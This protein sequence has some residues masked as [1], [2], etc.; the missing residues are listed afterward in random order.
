MD[1][2]FRVQKIIAISGRCSR[3]K[4]EEL[5]AEGRVV[6]NGEVVKLGDK[7]SANDEI[8]IDGEV[9]E[10]KPLEPKYIILN[11]KVGFV[12][13]NKDEFNMDTVFNLIS[14]ED[15]LPNMFTVGRLDKDTSGLLIITNDGSFAQKIIHPSSKICKEYVVLI[16]RKLMP[17]DKKRIE[18]GVVLDG[19]KVMPS[20]IK[21]MGHKADNY[22]YFV[23]IWEGR[24]RQVRRMFEMFS[25]NV[26]SLKRIKI[27]GLDLNEFELNE[28]EYMFVT[29]EF[30]ER[31]IFG[32]EL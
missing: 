2:V 6:V 27:G 11:K 23:K 19:Y 13:S 14:E 28:G 10:V 8:V 4:A 16:D 22:T 26:L 3:R 12:C 32:S 29:K 1:G 7:C 20:M 24:K 21:K 30:L 31:K 18:M 17:N 15:Y 25:Y 9:L 5:I